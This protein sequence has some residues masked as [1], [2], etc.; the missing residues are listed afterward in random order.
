MAQRARK[1]EEGQR[2]RFRRKI[3]RKSGPVPVSSH[4]EIEEEIEQHGGGIDESRLK[5]E[6]PR[7]AAKPIVSVDGKDVDEDHLRNDKAA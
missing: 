5:I 4:P 2:Q 7:P 6:N 1:R 3:G